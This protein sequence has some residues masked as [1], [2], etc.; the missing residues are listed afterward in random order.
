ME[1]QVDVL[2]DTHAL[3]L[4][5]VSRTRAVADPVQEVNYLL[6]FFESSRLG[7]C[8]GRHVD[9][10]WIE[11]AYRK[12]VYKR[13]RDK[14]WRGVPNT[15]A[16]GAFVHKAAVPISMDGIGRFHYNSPRSSR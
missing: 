10:R 3:H 8:V 7:L 5:D 9:G 13:Y 11:R 15:P 12:R 14:G 16:A 1:L 2:V 4:L 6:I